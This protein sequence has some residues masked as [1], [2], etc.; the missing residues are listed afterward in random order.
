MFFLKDID[1]EVTK[2]WLIACLCPGLSDKMNNLRSRPKIGLK[3]IAIQ[4]NYALFPF[5]PVH[6]PLF[7]QYSQ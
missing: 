1:D 4:S 7:F 6:L 3:S 2:K 5:L